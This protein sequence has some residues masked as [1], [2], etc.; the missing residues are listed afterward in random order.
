M[1]MTW[2]ALASM[3]A[4]LKPKE[5]TKLLGSACP[6][7][8]ATGSSACWARA[9]GAARARSETPIRRL[10]MSVLHTPRLDQHREV[11]RTRLAR[12]HG[13]PRKKTLPA[14]MSRAG[15]ELTIEAGHRYLV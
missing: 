1:A 2:R 3:F 6:E 9:T 4:L 5:T 11:V 10:L 14:G 8:V 12:R 13:T 15:R 7:T